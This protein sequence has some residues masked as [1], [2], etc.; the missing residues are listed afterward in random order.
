M[1]NLFTKVPGA[2][3]NESAGR[4]WTCELQP[5][6]RGVDS[7]PFDDFVRSGVCFSAEFQAQWEKSQKG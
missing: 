3:P 1:F 6:G 7:L 4:C 2:G 5:S